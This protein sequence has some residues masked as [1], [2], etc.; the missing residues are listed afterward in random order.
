MP[1]VSPTLEAVLTFPTTHL[2]ALD[3]PVIQEL[4]A[5]YHIRPVIYTRTPQHLVEPLGSLGL[6]DHNLPKDYLSFYDPLNLI[7]AMAAYDGLQRRIL[8]RDEA[9]V[10]HVGGVSY[11]E[12]NVTLDY[13]NAR[14]LDQ[15]FAGPFR[16]RYRK[17]LFGTRDPAS[18]RERAVTGGAE[19]FLEGI[20]RTIDRIADVMS[21]D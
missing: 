2:L 20:D 19:K 3:V 21:Q 5:T 8:N 4:M 17:P 14:L 1:T 12:E 13:F 10:Y 7:L 9:A 15:P 18:A 6:G 16:D 11:L